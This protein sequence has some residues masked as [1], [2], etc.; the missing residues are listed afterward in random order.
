[1][2][3]CKWKCCYV[4]YLLVI[5]LYFFVVVS[6]NVKQHTFQY[7]IGISECFYGNKF[8]NILCH[9]TEKKKKLNLSLCIKTVQSKIFFIKNSYKIKKKV[10]MFKFSIAEK[11][12][13]SFFKIS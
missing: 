12:I 10:L 6:E 8:L 11:D 1:M 3:D 4:N 13:M 2:N 9:R 5:N 7:R